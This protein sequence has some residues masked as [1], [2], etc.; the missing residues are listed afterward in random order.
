MST[1]LVELLPRS[2]DDLRRAEE[3]LLHLHFTDREDGT[4]RLQMSLCQDST[5][6]IPGVM[7]DS[8][9]ILAMWLLENAAC[10]F[11]K[12]VLELGCGTACAGLVAGALGAKVV[13]TDKSERALQLAEQ[14]AGENN[15]P[16]MQFERWDWREAMPVS[17]LGADII[18]A[19]D[20]VYTKDGAKAL[21]AALDAAADPSCT[22]LVVFKL[23]NSSVKPAI[24]TFLN[25]AREL[26]AECLPVA[27]PQTIGV[28]V[29]LSGGGRQAEACNVRT[30]GVYVY[31]LRKQLYQ[32]SGKSAASPPW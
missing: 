6:G 23:R 1:T 17:C 9:L 3:T 18:L 22:V 24:L 20:I 2:Y 14:A 15:L 8:A 21:L 13:C 27:L 12:K 16:S 11:Q 19:A 10:L 30:D 32:P 28:D 26:F 29:C 5:V 7:Y 25:G 4:S 31:R